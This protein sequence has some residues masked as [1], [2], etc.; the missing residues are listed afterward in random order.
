MS[1][2]EMEYEVL[3]AGLKR[4]R[5]MGFKRLQ[6]YSDSQLVVRKV[7][8]EYQAMGVNMISYLTKAK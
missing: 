5:S 2:N 8:S 7:N 6:V 1:N 4:T 3:I